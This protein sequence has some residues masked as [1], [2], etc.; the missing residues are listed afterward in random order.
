[1]SINNLVTVKFMGELGELFGTEHQLDVVTPVDVIRAIGIQNDDFIRY[2]NESSEK[3]IVYRLY[4]MDY[5]EGLGDDDLDY[6]IKDELVIIPTIQGEGGGF[7]K[8]VLGATLIGAAFLTGGV[9]LLGLAVSG[10]TMGLLGAALI[11]S[12]VSQMLAPDPQKEKTKKERE[13]KI[14]GNAGDVSAQGR[15][16]PLL[17]GETMV[18]DPYIISSGIV[19]EVMSEATEG[20]L[21]NP[22]YKRVTQVPLGYKAK[23]VQNYTY[24]FNPKTFRNYGVE[25]LSNK[26]PYVG[27]VVDKAP[28]GSL[29]I[30]FR[31]TSTPSGLKVAAAYPLQKIRIYS[32][33][34]GYTGATRVEIFAGSVQT[35]LA[36]LASFGLHFNAVGSGQKVYTEYDLIQYPQFW[37]PYPVFTMFFYSDLNSTDYIAV[38]EVELLGC[39]GLDEPLQNLWV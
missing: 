21:V 12:G 38:G 31:F 14:I 34:E 26:D 36:G 23:P 28:F 7:G 11:L 17:Y 35:G 39:I 37:Q 33:C 16:V 13:S 2:L 5:P 22:Q 6:P 25:Y 15:S 20:E 18:T 9:S 3:G 10:S 27:C 1:M 32:G 24:R 4:T 8:V 30:E 19:D 29:G